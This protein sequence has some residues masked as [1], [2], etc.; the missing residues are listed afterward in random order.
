[1]G[2]ALFINILAMLSTGVAAGLN[3]S[4]GYTGRGVSMVCLFVLNLVIFIFNLWRLLE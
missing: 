3:F 1:M 2:L 4:C